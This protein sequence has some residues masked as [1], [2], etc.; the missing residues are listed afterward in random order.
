MRIVVADARAAARSALRLRL[1]QEPGL[2]VVGEAATA[3][4]LTRVASATQPDLIVLDWGLPGM[5]PAELVARVRRRRPLVFV[6]ALSGRPEERAIA[7]AAGVDAFVNKGDAPE[8]LLAAVQ[9]AR[10]RAAAE[11]R[12]RAAP[13]SS[14]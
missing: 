4:Q 7:L 6:L 2:T 10:R 1:G 14:G 12:G 9:V 3:D 5:P 13:R 8:R 11:P